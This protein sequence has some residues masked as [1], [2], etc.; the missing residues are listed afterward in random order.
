MSATM[1]NI[2][3]QLLLCVSCNGLS[4]DSGP[5]S[6][7]AMAV[8]PSNNMAI[9]SSDSNDIISAYQPSAS[10]AE[11]PVYILQ[12][13]L[14]TIQPSISAFSGSYENGSSVSQ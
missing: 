7:K 11:K 5:G 14:C 6:M 3:Q 8:C 9:L 1:A 2:S 13:C 12:L 4:I 10:S